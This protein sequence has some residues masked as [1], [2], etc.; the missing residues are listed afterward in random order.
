MII[1]K[2]EIKMKKAFK[3]V[4]LIY[5]FFFASHSFSDNAKPTLP[6]NIQELIPQGE[7]GDLKSQLKLGE[8]FD[9]KAERALRD[10]VQSLYWYEKAAKQNDLKAQI[11][12]SRH[13]RNALG[14]KLDLKKAEYWAIKA[15]EQGDAKS[16]SSLAMFYMNNSNVYTNSRDLALPWLRKAAQQYDADGLYLLNSY[17]F[18]EKGAPRSHF[19]AQ[20]ALYGV[21]VKRNQTYGSTI[22]LMTN[23]AE[24][25]MNELSPDEQK[26][27]EKLINEMAVDGEL[28]GKLGLATKDSPCI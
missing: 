21:A 2:M 5:S 7:S 12:T 22:K 10:P 1:Q 18:E 16:Q 27:A 23:K 6:E 28:L 24:V 3:C 8:Y 4:V 25:F 14:T 15:A 9:Y 19:V 13:Y 20:A 17:C 11:E 26:A